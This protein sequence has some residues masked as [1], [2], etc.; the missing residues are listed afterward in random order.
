MFVL[1]VVIAVLV[2]GGELLI[3][4]LEPSVL[5]RLCVAVV[6]VRRRSG[7]GLRDRS[8]MR[9]RGVRN[10]CKGNEACR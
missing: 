5:D 10:H 6:A 2:V 4:V 8:E 1:D 9:K 7:I 3:P